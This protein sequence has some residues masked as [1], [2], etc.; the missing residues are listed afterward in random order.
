MNLCRKCQFQPWNT[1]FCFEPPMRSNWT[2]IWHLLITSTAAKHFAKTFI[3]WQIGGK[4]QLA[5]SANLHFPQGRGPVCHNL[6]IFLDSR[7]DLILFPK[8]TR[9]K[10]LERCARLIRSL[11][12]LIRLIWIGFFWVD[13]FLRIFSWIVS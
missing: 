13:L 3:D 5:F 12:W 4:C 2:S 8:I 11:Y 7:V 1:T 9:P 10:S 6:H